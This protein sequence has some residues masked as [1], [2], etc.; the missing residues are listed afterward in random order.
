VVRL[1][2][3]AWAKDG[4]YSRWNT[5]IA[6]VIYSEDNAGCPV[7]LD[8]ESDILDAVAEVA[9]VEAI[10]PRDSLVDAVRQTLESPYHPD[11]MFCRHRWRLRAWRTSSAGGPPPDLGL[12]AVLSLA[13]EDMREGDG[14]SSNNYYQRLMPLLGYSTAASKNRITASYRECS[15]EL[16]GA[17][18]TW[19]EGLDG[20][21]GVPTAFA[22]THAHIGP[23]MS[24]ALVRAAD[25]ARILELFSELH[26]P[27]RSD[28]PSTEMEANLADWVQHRASN[29]L[30][31]L[32]RS[33]DARARIVDCA[34]QLLNAWDGADTLAAAQHRT[35]RLQLTILQRM[36]PTPRLELNIVG[37]DLD[38]TTSEASL[39]GPG[40]ED[41]VRGSVLLSSVPGSRWRLQ[42]PTALDTSS[43]LEGQLTLRR[44]GTTFGRRPRALVALRKDD[45][46]QAFVEVERL[47]LGEAA[48]VFCTDQLAAQVTKALGLIARPGFTSKQSPSGC[49]SGW[50]LFS[51]VQVLGNLPERAPDGTQWPVDLNLLQPLTSSQM[52][53][54]GG[55]RLPGRLRSYSSLAP[56]EFTIVTAAD[57][58]LHVMLRVAGD[59]DAGELI[60]E[61][62]VPRN[63]M[64][65]PL[66]ALH[67]PDGNYEISASLGST[68]AT[69]VDSIAVRLRSADSPIT[70][71]H[72]DT[73]LAR[74]LA[75][76]PMAVIA[77]VADSGGP[78]IEGAAVL[79]ADP[80]TLS[81]SHGTTV[82]SLP[83]WWVAR[84][85]S[86]SLGPTNLARIV[87]PAIGAGDCF[88]T[89]AH[90]MDLPT[91]GGKQHGSEIRGVCRK[92]GLLKRYPARL[93]RLPPTSPNKAKAV[94]GP[95]FDPTTVAPLDPVRTIDVNVAFDLTFRTS[96]SRLRPPPLCTFNSDELGILQLGQ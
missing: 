30:R 59:D 84:A 95:R 22:R 93:P 68:T 74:V 48:L 40:G 82:V 20:E 58:D 1:P 81:A 46:L 96:R 50:T 83:P 54:E 17:L 42:D 2:S 8:L 34:R 53:L 64:I 45:L 29:T 28:L 44:G 7:Y 86:P 14:H 10:Q 77:A 55:L 16:W 41:D 63:T 5:A 37:P 76:A 13:A 21:R 91:F 32:W 60:A 90:H 39:I 38:E 56:P 61:Q 31:S 23:P 71:P 87:V 92:C 24:Q 51:G 72:R 6:E 88:L 11:G 43:L 19:L 25:R 66:E 4:P 65:W 94:V 49:P 15:S 35:H 62:T 26:L 85:A 52:S 27:A 89:G 70:H 33:R 73:A 18:N 36:F 67:L 79:E 80:Q 69:P 47:P 78:R 57:G 12:L 3:E 9:G 75:D